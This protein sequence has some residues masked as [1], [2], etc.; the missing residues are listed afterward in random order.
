M[1]FERPDPLGGLRLLVLDLVGLVDDDVLPVELLEGV[2]TDPDAFK[3]GDADV[4]LS[5]LQ[6]VLENLFTFL[7]GCYQVTDSAVWIPSF[8][9]GFPV[10]DYRLRHDD[11][12]WAFDVLK[13][14]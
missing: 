10:S 12:M 4:E 5:W 3:S 9:F 14:V 6:L 1:G 7:F 2:L 8:E 13:L 11:E